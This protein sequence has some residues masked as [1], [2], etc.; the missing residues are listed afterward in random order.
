MRTRVILFL[1]GQLTTELNLA[2]T[3]PALPGAAGLSD[4]HANRSLLQQRFPGHIK[5]LEPY[6]RPIAL[7]EMTVLDLL[8][9]AEL[10]EDMAAEVR[11]SF[12]VRC[13]L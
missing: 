4:V 1:R 5:P 9:D 11:Q 8:L 13:R 6:G 3:G 12:A 10:R 7:G 2:I